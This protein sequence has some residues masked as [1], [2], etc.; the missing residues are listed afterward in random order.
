MNGGLAMSDFNK[1]QER[2]LQEPVFAEE[3]EPLRPAYEVIQALISART[4]C[5]M[6]QKELAEKTGI[7]QSNISR[8]ESGN[9]NPTMDT[10]AR[11]AEGMGKKLHIEFQ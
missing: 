8:I 1:H 11:L 5:H 3:Y 10:L 6:T 2:S 7:R 9:T 4:E